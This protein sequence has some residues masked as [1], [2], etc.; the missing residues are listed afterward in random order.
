MRK[1]L[2]KEAIAERERKERERL[3][4]VN[5]PNFKTMI[6]ALEKDVIT[7]VNYLFNKSFATSDERNEQFFKTQAMSK[8]LDRIRKTLKTISE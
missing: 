8:Q 1:P 4:F 2:T 7:Q 6:R 3:A 5:N